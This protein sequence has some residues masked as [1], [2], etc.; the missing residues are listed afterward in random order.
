MKRYIF[1]FCLIILA[2]KH[3]FGQQSNGRVSSLIAAEN[4]FA[5]YAKDKGIR[6]AFLKI[7]DESTVLFKP[8]PL[9]ATEFYNKKSSAD[10]GKLQWTP[11]FAKI[12]KSGDWG[13]TTG[14]YSYHDLLSATTI[15]GQYLSVWRTNM[16]GVWKLALQINMKHSK[17]V[18]EIPLHFIDPVNLRFFKQISEGRLKQREEM[19]KSSDLLFSNTLMKNQRLAYDTFFADEGRLLFPDTEPIIGKNNAN[20]FFSRQQIEVET[21]PQVAN[22]SLGS[23]LAYTYGKAYITKN[24]ETK[25]L[26]YVRI[27]ESQEGYTWNVVLEIFSPEQH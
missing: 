14:P 24:K 4:Y 16:K 10:P 13:F 17:P 8:N 12:S 6:D 25:R 23:D 18:V 7:S 27:W 1:L 9:K 15:F 3:N 11:T 2:S 20:N 5:A 19:I 22:R 21:I 26:N